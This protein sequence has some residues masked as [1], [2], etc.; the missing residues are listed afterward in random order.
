MPRRSKLRTR[1]TFLPLINLDALLS[2]AKT[3]RPNLATLTR[4]RWSRLWPIYTALRDNGFSCR[5]AVTWLAR[6]G[7][8]P[9]GDETRARNAFHVLATRR[10]RQQVIANR[11][12]R[13][14][15]PSRRS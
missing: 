7:A 12:R 9:F 11:K 4:R 15:I 3:A 14:A 6:Q 8:V 10:N 5:S 13:L 1:R 2:K